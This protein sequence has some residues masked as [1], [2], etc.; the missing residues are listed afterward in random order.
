LSG[1]GQP[2]KLLFLIPEDWYVCSHRLPL[3][4]GARAEGLDVAVVT[5]VGKEAEPIRAAGAVVVPARLR[6]GFRNPLRDL[7]G[8][9]ELVRIYRAQGPAI[10]HHVTPK[11]C[12]FGSLAAMTTGVPAVINAMAGL[13]FL[14]S[15]NGLQARLARPLVKVAFRF[16]LSRPG[17]RMIVQNNE[18]GDFFRQKIGVPADRIVLIRGSGVDVERFHPVAGEPAGRI[19]F[20]LVARMIS[21]K[22]LSETVAAS[23]R[24]RAVRQDIE[25][26][27]AGEPDVENPSGVSAA[28]LQAWHDEGVITWLGRVDDVA[29]VLNT[30]HVGLL[31]S[32]YREG[33]PKSLLE[34]AAC[35]LPLIATDTTGCREICLDGVNGLHVK[36]RDVASLVAAVT[37]LADDPEL[38]ARLG[39]ESRRLVVENFSEAIVVRQTMALYR[40]LLG[41]AVGHG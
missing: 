10:A 39:R 29:A 40:E 27:F 37:T 26:V 11:S 14:Y 25:F 35:G 41:G 1:L 4:V 38:R 32:Y 8:L 3:I 19:R 6:R 31:P 16:I 20:C 17:S 12:L 24:L 13:G 33:L 23:R 28:Q 9:F 18:D 15:S 2:R 7:G 22:G 30:C 34:A 36:T 5:R 21:E